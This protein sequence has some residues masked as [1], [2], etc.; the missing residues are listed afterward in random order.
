M[1]CEGRDDVDILLAA[2]LLVAGLVLLFF[3]ARWLVDGASALAL[4]K[5]I[6]R[7]VV[8]LTIVALGTSAPEAILAFFSS[9]EGA[10]ELSLGNVLGANVAN[11]ALILGVS[12]L[13]APLAIKVSAIWRQLVFLVLSLFLL[14]LFALDGRYSLLDGLGLFLTLLAFFTVL[15]VV[16]VRKREAPAFIEEELEDV[17]EVRR[18]RTNR[19]IYLLIVVGAA[20]LTLGAQAVIVGA[21]DIARFAGVQ[22][23]VIGYTLIAFGTTIPELTVGITGS[24]KGELEVVLGNVLG[25]VIMNS[26]FVIGIGAV[27]AGFDVTGPVVWAGLVAMAGFVLGTIILVMVT[28][29]ISRPMGAVLLS[30]YATYLL[31]VVFLL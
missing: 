15:Y 24:R 29:R 6:S 1:V 22:E 8:G 31:V 14:I 23:E 7:L 4:K 21:T 16:S 9:L 5:G 18:R 26:L 20:L 2:G 10:N 12:S 11:I 27:V 13:I 17:Q 30:L 3:G 19:F 25:T 28:E